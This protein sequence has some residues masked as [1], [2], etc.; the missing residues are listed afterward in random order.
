MTLRTMIGPACVLVVLSCGGDGVSGQDGVAGQQGTQGQQGTAGP[1]GP[2]GPA[3]M[4]GRDALGASDTN[5]TRLKRYATVVTAADGLQATL[6]GYIYRDTMLGIDCGFQTATDGTLRCLPS[7]AKGDVA[8]ASATTG[9]FADAGCTQPLVYALKPC[10]TLKY[11]LLMSSSSATC[12]PTSQFAVY[13]AP[14]PLTPS[15]MY[16][17]SPGSC[18]AMPK[19]SI[20]A[21][22]VSFAFFDLNGKTP[23][24]PASFAAGTSTQVLL[25]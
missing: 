22:L 25:P 1:Q 23:A 6:P 15:T 2:A 3:G 24:N 11:L 21:L 12:P 8:S 14:S 9:Y 10:A 20:D 5:G 7:S 18:T 13:A 16:S 4:N 19:T 17:G